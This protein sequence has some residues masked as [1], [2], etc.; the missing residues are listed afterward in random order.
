VFD[1]AVGDQIYD[2]AV[3]DAAIATTAP[4]TTETMQGW[5][6]ALVVLSS[7]IV[8][9]LLVVVVQVATALRR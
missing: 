5:A 2:A 4:Q 3:G 1:A 7:I 6:V 9:L 8:V